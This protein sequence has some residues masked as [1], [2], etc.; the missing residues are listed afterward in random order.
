MTD[1]ILACFAHKTRSWPMVLQDLVLR[2]LLQCAVHKVTSDLYHISG[3]VALMWDAVSRARVTSQEVNMRNDRDGPTQRTWE[4]S[5]LASLCSRHSRTT[6]SVVRIYFKAR[7]QNLISL[8][9]HSTSPKIASQLLSTFS[10]PILS[11]ILY[12]WIRNHDSKTTHISSGDPDDGPYIER[13][14]PHKELGERRR[15]HNKCKIILCLIL[16]ISLFLNFIALFGKFARE[17]TDHLLT[18]SPAS[19][20]IKSEK[21][22]FSSAFGIQ[23]SPFQGQPTPRKDKLWEDLYNFGI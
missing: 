7:R 2:N 5:G 9:R 1:P 23:V 10:M 6:L 17:N 19:P 13:L 18:Y 21:V 14:I 16:L 8:S 4:E 11:K 3:I 15:T 20:V 12:A 22:V